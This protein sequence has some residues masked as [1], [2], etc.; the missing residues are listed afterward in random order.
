M[1]EYDATFLISK[2]HDVSA[3]IL[4]DQVRGHILKLIS[5]AY[6]NLSFKLS[7]FNLTIKWVGDYSMLISIT[8]AN[9]KLK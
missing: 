3:T 7:H 5:H 4:I 6:K 8:K 1:Q 9:D 2:F